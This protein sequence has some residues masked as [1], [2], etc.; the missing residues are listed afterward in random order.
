MDI[1]IALIRYAGAVGLVSLGLVV[2]GA[3]LLRSEPS[4]VTAAAR[5]PIVP[6]KILDSI[7]RKKP[8]LVDVVVPPAVRPAL[9]LFQSA[10]VALSQPAPPQVVRE[11]PGA[12][13]KTHKIR[14]E[15]EVVEA[16]GLETR[17]PRSP[18]T[19]NATSRSD[20]P[21]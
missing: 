2:G 13:K 3:W 8:I 21:Y 9:P 16:P 17:V 11:L 18:S 15:Q 1:V 12:K 4:A 7:E 19:H 6:Q 20:F 5:T 10:T 14:R